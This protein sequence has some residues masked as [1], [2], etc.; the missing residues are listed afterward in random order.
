MAVRFLCAAV[1]STEEEV[2]VGGG[3][4]LQQVGG[5]SVQGDCLD[6][7]LSLDEF[8]QAEFQ[9]EL[10]QGEQGVASVRDDRQATETD[11]VEP[12][13]TQRL[14]ADVQ[15]V[16]LFQSRDVLS[17]HTSEEGILGGK[18]HT[19]ANHDCR[20]GYPGSNLPM[21]LK[22]VCFYTFCGCKSSLKQGLGRMIGREI[23]YFA[24]LCANNEHL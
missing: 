21:S 17:C 3:V 2:I 19:D 16:V 1:G 5:Q 6:P 14:V 8:P 9:V 20:S 10:L 22:H 7:Y 15:T 13:E 23:E 12:F 4:V 24:Y 18:E 11:R